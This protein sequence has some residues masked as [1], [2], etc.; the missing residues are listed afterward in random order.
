MKIAFLSLYY[1]QSNRGAETFVSELSS[2]LN[3][4]NTVDVLSGGS[5]KLPN[6][7]VLWR[8]FLDPQ[9]IAGFVFAFKN[10]RKIWREKYDIVI[11]LDGGW[12][13]LIVR[14]LTWLYGGKV[15]IS[16]QSGKGWFDRI[17]ILTCPNTFVSLSKWTEAKLRWM[18]PFIS[19]KHIS[20]GWISKNLVQVDKYSK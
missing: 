1:G 7:P 5:K 6:W 12:E 8:F 2:R 9:G 17:N 15:V 11:P 4:K 3:R 10:I 13:A 19:F 20:N 16:G 18:N 14:K